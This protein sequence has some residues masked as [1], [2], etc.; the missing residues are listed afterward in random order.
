MGYT[1]GLKE[2]FDTPYS[3][4]RLEEMEERREEKRG[5]VYEYVYLSI[6]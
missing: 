5:E 2:V 4:F 1:L 6:S 3:S